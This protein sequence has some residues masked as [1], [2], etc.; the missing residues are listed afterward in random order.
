MQTADKYQH[1]VGSKR[2]ASLSPPSRK[3]LI[4]GTLVWM[5]LVTVLTCSISSQPTALGSLLQHLPPA[6]LFQLQ[7]T[8][9]FSTQHKRRKYDT[10]LLTVALTTLTHPN[11]RGSMSVV[12]SAAASRPWERQLLRACR[13]LEAPRQQGL[14]LPPHKAA[15][16]WSCACTSS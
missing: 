2:L 13:A 1:P 15:G 16:G 12:S 6:S 4:K 5:L 11:Q 8:K 7:Q 9:I 14:L 3:A 10:L